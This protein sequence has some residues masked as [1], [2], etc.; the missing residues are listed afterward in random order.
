MILVLFVQLGGQVQILRNLHTA[1]D[2]IH[3]HKALLRE[4]TEEPEVFQMSQT[5]QKA[6]LEDYSSKEMT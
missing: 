1:W 3:E 2:W 4:E 6:A 5:T